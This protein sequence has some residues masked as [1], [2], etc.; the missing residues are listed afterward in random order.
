ML[1]LSGRTED[2]AGGKYRNILRELRYVKRAAGEAGCISYRRLPS[3][4]YFCPYLPGTLFSIVYFLV[5][6]LYHLLLS[7]AIII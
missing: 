4:C 1:E 3:S 5:L 2:S 6:L 7:D